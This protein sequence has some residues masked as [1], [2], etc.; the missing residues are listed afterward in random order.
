MIKHG[1][2]DHIYYAA[3]SLLH[4]HE[5]VESSKS[6]HNSQSSERT[7]AQHKL[8]IFSV[9]T[10]P[11]CPAQSSPWV[12]QTAA[13]YAATHV[14]MAHPQ[15]TPAHPLS[16][17][18][19]ALETS[20]RAQRGLQQANEALAAPRCSSTRPS[21]AQECGRQHTWCRRLAL[22]SAPVV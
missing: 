21:I 4:K 15:A 12:I 1:M 2:E 13:L 10:L 6:N 22:G 11:E 17:Q 18:S 5:G 16:R 8:D 9:V 19:Q 14:Q 3:C 20:H 7:L